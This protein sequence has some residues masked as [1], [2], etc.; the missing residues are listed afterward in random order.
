M[1]IGV[2]SNGDVY[3]FAKASNE[4]YKLYNKKIINIVNVDSLIMLVLENGK[5]CEVLPDNKLIC[6]NDKFEELKDEKIVDVG[7]NGE[8]ILE[9][10]KAYYSEPGE[11]LICINEMFDEL[12][13]EKIVNI[14]RYIIILENG[15]AYYPESES[16]LKCINEMFDE[17]KNEKIVNMNGAIILE[18]G[19]AYYPESESQLT[20]INEMFDEIKNEKII[21]I[22][23][24]GE[25]I[26]ENG[27]AYYLEPENQLICIND[28]FEALKN[29]NI[30]NIIYTSDDTEMILLENG[31]IYNVDDNEF[32][33]YNQL[34]LILKGKNIE[35]ISSGG[36]H[37]VA[38][39]ENGK[40][41]TWGRNY[42]G[43]L[44]DGTNNSNIP[45]CI[46][47]I[48]TNPLNKVKIKEISAGYNHTVA[49]DE[50]GKVYAWGYNYR[51]QLGDG[52]NNDSNIPICISDIPTNP[53]NKVKIKEISAGGSH[54]VAIDE[55]GKVYAWGVNYN[56]QLGNG[57]NNNSNIPICISDISTNL[58]SIKEISAGG[59]HTVAI[60]EEGKVYA[61]GDN[62][63]GQLG[64]GTN[65]DS[66]IPMCISD[67]PT[68][69]L[70]KVKIKKI[71]ADAHTVAIDEEG[72]VY[73]WGYNWK[74]Q[75]GDGTTNDIN[76]PICISDIS[77]NELYNKKSSKISANGC[78]TIIIDE[79]G[80]IYI[81][82]GSIPI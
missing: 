13:N 40:V 41:Y 48:P 3:S 62:Y 29:E 18:N 33:N 19:K 55:E 42:D 8:I 64:D 31:S 16:Q 79:N 20:C 57:T 10:G 43:Q 9:N 60:D 34:E 80:E 4:T 24:D 81:F 26:L 44:G 76:E 73:A 59:S 23:Y 37:T 14:N 28:K 67:I 35:K 17:L 30:V 2:D 52:T 39:D 36:S 50:D 51:G 7:Y 70:N 38:L 6:I 71:S 15:K 72:K 22:G 54:T 45:I 49:I 69:P 32:V 27:K 11:Q 5:A 82:G 77:G 21:N 65:N 1:N 53:L 66:N 56:G 12:K 58:V 47:D 78:W 25:I 63:F 68:N 61:W 46:S 75:L 74:G